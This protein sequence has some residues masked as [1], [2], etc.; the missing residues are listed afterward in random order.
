MSDALGLSIGTTNLVA[1]R[2]G[3]EPLIRSSVL[4]LLDGR[5]AEV[6]VPSQNP[7]LNR[8]EV[9]QSGL[10]LRGFVERVG[11]PVALVATD[12]SAHRGEILVAVAMEAMAR[13]ADTGVPPTAVAVTAPAHWGPA[14]IGALRG[15]LRGSPVLSP[16]GTP[17]L[18]VSDADAALAALRA[19]P[20]LPE[21]GVVALCDFGGGGSS[22]TLADAGAN[23]TPIGETIRFADFSGDRID[24]DLLEQVLSGI[25]A[26]G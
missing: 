14:T 20:G 10:V 23:L 9:T 19:D 12:G 24:R 17:P 6:G 3:G 21:R 8:P 5:P 25:G 1:V 13:A 2:P 26:G 22:V 15:A 16:G 7:A 11:D 4:T 18:I